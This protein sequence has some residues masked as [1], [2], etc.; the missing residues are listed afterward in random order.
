MNRIMWIL[1]IRK[2]NSSKS[3][4][5]TIP[6][7]PRWRLPVAQGK[8]KAKHKKKSAI[9]K[10]G[11]LPPV[12]MASSLVVRCNGFVRKIALDPNGTSTL[13]C[14]LN[15]Q[16]RA[17]STTGL[18]KEPSLPS[19]QTVCESGESIYEVSIMTSP[20]VFTYCFLGKYKKVFHHEFQSSFYFQVECLPK[21]WRL[22]RYL[23][24]KCVT[25]QLFHE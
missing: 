5:P 24:Q 25:A 23:I 7:A 2:A 15:Q 17:L 11:K 13:K 8:A 10:P 12:Q 20:I 19:Q 6:R 21:G 3:K 1:K 9:A 4:S 16:L 22:L 14:V 18:K